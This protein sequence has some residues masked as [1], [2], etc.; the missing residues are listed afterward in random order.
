[1]FIFFAAFFAGALLLIDRV[2]GIIDKG[3]MSRYESIEDL[4]DSLRDVD[5]YTPA[6]FPRTLAWPP[7][8][9]FAQSTPYAFV[10][11]ELAAQDGTP[12]L[13]IT[14][15]DASKARRPGSIS[16]SSSLVITDVVESITIPLRDTDAAL[17]VG[18]CGD[19]D[20]RGENCSSISWVE[21]NYRLT[22][23]GRIEPRELLRTAGSM[24]R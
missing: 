12:A 24:R 16:G 15:A 8:S 2:P 18:P 11:M 19:K 20:A 1:M 4:R 5:I 17:T 14:Q 9:I 7:S 6:Y 23:T 3:V 22:I 21:G 10:V 13:I